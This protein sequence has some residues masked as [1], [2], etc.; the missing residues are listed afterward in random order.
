M[1]N[2]ALWLERARRARERIH[3]ARARHASVDLGLTMVERDSD[4]GGAPL[5]GVLAHRLFVLLLPTALLLVSG[6]GLY[7]GATDKSPA[8]QFVAAEAVGWIRRNDQLGGV[9]ALSVYLVLVGGAWL[10]VSTELPHRDARWPALLPGSVLF[11]LGLLFVNV[12]NVY[13]TTRLVEGR[14]DTYGALGIATALL[15]SLVLVGRL[16]ILSAEVN[17]LLDERRRRRLQSA[18]R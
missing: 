17:A 9:A 4:I 2:R 1:P 14:A 11:G 18:E 8:D 16:M 15:S 10:V 3:A 6:V 13:V 12:F 7:A 5:A